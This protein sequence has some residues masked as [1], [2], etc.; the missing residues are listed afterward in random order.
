MRI[1]SRLN[2]NIQLTNRHT[3]KAILVLRLLSVMAQL[4]VIAVVD[5]GLNITLPREALLVGTWL[6]ALSI[7]LTFWRLHKKW[8]IT[9]WEVCAHIVLDVAALTWLFYFSGGSTNAF[10]FAYLVPIAIAAIALRLHYSIV[11]TVLS[12][13][14]YTLLFRFYVPLSPLANAA[15]TDFELHVIGMWINF[16]LSAGLIAGLIWWLADN[17]RQRD[18]TIAKARE[19]TLRNEHIVALGTLAA[20]AAHELS[21]PLSTAALLAEELTINLHRDS[22]AKDD[23]LLLKQ[24]IQLCKTSL[25]TLLHA[26]GAT[27]VDNEEK[28]HHINEVLANVVTR[29]TLLR[30]EITLKTYV[31][32]NMDVL[33]PESLGF[34]QAIINILNNAA[35]AS[36]DAGSDTV[37]F[38]A[39]RNDKQVLLRIIDEGEGVND[40]MQQLAG[41]AVYSTKPEGSGLGLLLSHATFERWGAQVSLHSLAEGGTL[42]R[43]VLPLA[44]LKVSS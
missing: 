27:R 25:T 34:S 37:L 31:E 36:R 18:A 26:A 6:L 14:A 19:I 24:Q 39:Q 7:P 8:P 9:Q 30:P 38:Y 40:V 21:T 16:I 10:V 17:V 32:K 22:L 13:V 23:A 33:L 1:K 43:I 15:I 42:T 4:T 2:F 29:W 41:R 5:M 28:A 44:N 11:I 20:S 35:D 12:I 3:L